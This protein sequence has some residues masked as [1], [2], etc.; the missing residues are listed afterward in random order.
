MVPLAR[1]PEGGFYLPEDV[2][3]RPGSRLHVHN[4]QQVLQD[5][6]QLFKTQVRT[7]PVQVPVVPVR[8]VQ[9]LHTPR[10]S[11]R[12]ALQGHIAEHLNP[13]LRPFTDQRQSDASFEC[14]NPRR[15]F[16]V[17]TTPEPGTVPGPTA[18]QA[19]DPLFFARGNDRCNS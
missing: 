9:G 7:A 19:K 2:H 6:E 4:V 12:T 17:P 10:P 1:T 8:R 15:S 13:S 18:R 14:L 5:V 11:G 3:G 16:L